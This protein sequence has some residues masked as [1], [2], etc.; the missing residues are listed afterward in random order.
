[1]FHYL[2][3]RQSMFDLKHHVKKKMTKVYVLCLSHWMG[4]V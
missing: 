4:G 2:K 3:W 1:M